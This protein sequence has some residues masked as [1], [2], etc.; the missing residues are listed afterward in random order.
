MPLGRMVTVDGILGQRWPSTSGQ[1]LTKA[2]AADLGLDPSFA[3]MIE[4]Y[5]GTTHIGIRMHDGSISIVTVENPHETDNTKRI[6]KLTGTDMNKQRTPG[7]PLR[8]IQLTPDM[9]TALQIDE[10]A[11]MTIQTKMGTLVSNSPVAEIVSW[12]PSVPCPAAANFPPTSIRRD[13][14][15]AVGG[16]LAVKQP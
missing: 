13:F 8:A 4:G 12:N 14:M 3:K 2:N 1:I 6:Y 7:A 5:A 10:G 11:H 9:V 16:T 15:A